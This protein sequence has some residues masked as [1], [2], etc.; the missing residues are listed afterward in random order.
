MVAGES[1]FGASP[2]SDDSA[3]PKSPLDTPLRYSHGSHSSTLRARFRYGGNNAE[4]NLM[5]LPLRSRT[6]GT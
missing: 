4:V 1:P 5:P 3:S 2:N 6:F